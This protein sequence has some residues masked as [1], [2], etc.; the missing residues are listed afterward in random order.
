MLVI[1]GVEFAFVEK[2]FQVGKF[3]HR[4]A[5]WL[6]A[7]GHRAQKIVDRWHMRQHI[8]AYD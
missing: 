5:I 3:E 7:G 8:I 2:L 6:Q 4:R 1:D